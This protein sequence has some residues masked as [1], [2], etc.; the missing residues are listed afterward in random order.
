MSLPFSANSKV[1]LLKV[2]SNKNFVPLKIS[3][4]LYA[5]NQKTKEHESKMVFI[6]ATKSMLTGILFTQIESV[7]VQIIYTLES[8]I[9]YK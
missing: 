1:I 9:N 4:Y 3:E 6:N 2:I 7:N 8:L 5:R